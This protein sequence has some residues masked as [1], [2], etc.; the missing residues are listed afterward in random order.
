MSRSLLDALLV[1]V[2]LV[3]LVFGALLAVV[4]GLVP[5]AIEDQIL[6]LERSLDPDLALLAIGVLVGLFAIW[7][8]YF[9]GASDVGDSAPTRDNRATAASDAR[10]TAATDVAVVGQRT[11]EDVDRIIEALQRGRSVDTDPIRADVRDALTTVETA[12]GHSPEAAAER[13]ATG[14]WTDDRIAATFLGDERAGRLT[15]WHRLR[16][17]LFPGRT[18]ERRL[19]RTLAELERYADARAAV[20][21][22]RTG[23]GSSG[24][25]GG[26]EDA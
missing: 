10:G 25:E 26:S 21:D 14:A 12:R 20:D 3:A 18:V 13:I 5:P 4:P 19:E 9:S 8:S 6:T 24:N 22:A 16:A 15:L 2:A 7:R 17:W 11:S 1:C 23:A